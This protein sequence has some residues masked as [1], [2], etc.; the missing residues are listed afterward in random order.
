MIYFIMSLQIYKDVVK[1]FLSDLANLS[2]GNDLES[3]AKLEDILAPA[4]ERER[5]LRMTFVTTSLP[6]LSDPHIGLI[7]VFLISPIPVIIGRDR[8]SANLDSMHLFPFL[9]FNHPL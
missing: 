5:N 4:L 1:K 8:T 6:M 2:P 3:Y 9:D 7:D